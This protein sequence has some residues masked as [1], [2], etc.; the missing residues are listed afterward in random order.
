MKRISLF[1]ILAA[2]LAIGCSDDSNDSSNDTSTTNFLPLQ[3]GNY[4]V[5]DV[6]GSAVNGRD[7]LFISGDTLI[8]GNTYKKLKTENPAFGFYSNALRNNGIRKSGDR[9][10]LTGAADFGFASEFPLSIN[11]SDYTIFKENAT[12]GQQL[13][14]VSGT[15]TQPYDG[16]SIVFNYTLSSTAKASEASHT[17][18]GEVYQNIHP[19]ETK[20]SLNVVAQFTVSGIT[21]PYTIMPQQDVVVSTQYYAENIGA[22]HVVTNI[23]Y[24]LADLSAL[25][26]AGVELPLPQSGSDSQEEKLDVYHLE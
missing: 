21:I 9:L 7:S 26:G 4:W 2:F 13:A 15:V 5:Y 20:L 24:Q 10:L 1:A 16:Y 14:S 11:V 25:A 18:N 17:V 19:V 6:E 23:N 12:A 8:T 3:T 22:V